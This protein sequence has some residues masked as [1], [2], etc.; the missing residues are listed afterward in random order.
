ML[1]HFVLLYHFVLDSYFRYL[2]DQFYVLQI[3]FDNIHKRN[4]IDNIKTHM[5]NLEYDYT[6]YKIKKMNNSYH[7]SL[8]GPLTFY[9]VNIDNIIKTFNKIKEENI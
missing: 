7:G 5:Q 6:L 1:G 8:S 9:N 2:T 3:E 4:I